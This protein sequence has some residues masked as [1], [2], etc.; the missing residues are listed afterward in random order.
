MNKDIRFEL[1]N[2]INNRIE[3]ISDAVDLVDLATKQQALQTASEVPINNPNLVAEN[4]QEALIELLGIT[5]LLD[6]TFVYKLTYVE[7]ISSTV[8]K[9]LD[10]A[11]VQSLNNN[12]GYVLPYNSKISLISFILKKSSILGNGDIT[13]NVKSNGNIIYS[14]NVPESELNTISGHE[15]IVEDIPVSKG[16]ILTASIQIDG[17][18]TYDDVIF[19]VFLT[20]FEDVV[21]NECQ[22]ILSEIVDTLPQNGLPLTQEAIELYN[23]LL[24]ECNEDEFN[25]YRVTFDPVVVCEG[26]TTNVLVEG[27]NIPLN[28]T[29]YYEI[30][31]EGI[32]QD[33]IDLNLSDEITLV[34]GKW[35]A[36]VFA[37]ENI[38][39]VPAETLT[40]NLYSDSS[41]N[42]LLAT[43]VLV[44]KENL[45]NYIAVPERPVILEGDSNRIFI[46][47]F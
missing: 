46:L 18:L 3:N 8:S 4:V 36:P 12:I 13:F 15:L 41:T 38:D 21:N 30:T 42:E 40:F 20:E 14:V 10:I 11:N 35:T 45:E 32:T 29:L 5:R 6:E 17:I 43:G 22:S 23:R 47:K 2:L 26:E 37:F 1:L 19:N 39:E 31:G 7:N 16:D 25:I 28:N 33:D 9:N 27:I 34:N 44:I 24:S